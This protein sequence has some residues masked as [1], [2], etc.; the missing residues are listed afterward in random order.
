MTGAT[1]IASRRSCP[2]RRAATS[3]SSTRQRRVSMRAR[4]STATSG[5]ASVSA[6]ISPS[7]SRRLPTSGVGPRWLSRRSTWSGSSATVTGSGSLARLPPRPR[8]AQGARSVDHRCP[9]TQRPS[10]DGMTSDRNGSESRLPAWQRPP[11]EPGHTLSL[12]H[13][14][15]SARVY[16]PI[17][18]ELVAAVLVERG[19][20]VPF[21]HAVEAWA[22]AEARAELLRSYLAEVSMFD[23][24]HEPRTGPLKWLILFEKR[25][26]AMRRR[27]GLDPLASAELARR[28]VEAQRSKVDLDGLRARGAQYVDATADD[29]SD[30][31]GDDSDEVGG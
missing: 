4:S 31:D 2:Q 7:C 30:L 8:M 12:K 5:R 21:R 27:L 3:R 26:D 16:E 6:S 23:E 18:K 22:D 29:D 25:A 28:Q 11:F 15:R 10:G 19:D 24:D 14:A 1:L 17:A 13:G 20:L 9:L